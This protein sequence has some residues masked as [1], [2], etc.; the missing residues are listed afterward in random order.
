MSYSFML[1]P[2]DETEGLISCGVK[3][4]LAF[5]GIRELMEN[6]IITLACVKFLQVLTIH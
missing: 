5:F 2:R 1:P 4:S 6:Q 3:N